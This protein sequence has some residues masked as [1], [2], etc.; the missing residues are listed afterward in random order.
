MKR[1]VP[2]SFEEQ[3]N[4]IKCSNKSYGNVFPVLR[5]PV[6]VQIYESIT[7][8]QCRACVQQILKR[9]GQSWSAWAFDIEW[10]VDFKVGGQRPVALMQFSR[11]N[12]VILF[13]IHRCGL[14]P[15]L[16]D[17]LKNP[18]IFL[19][20]VNISGDVKKIER[21]FATVLPGTIKGAVDLR[22]LEWKLL[23]H[24]SSNSLAGM[25]QARLRMTLEK[26][27]DVRTGNWEQN[28]TK[29]Q[30]DYAAL[31]VFSTYLLFHDIMKSVLAN[32]SVKDSNQEGFETP[33]AI[34]TFVFNTLSELSLKFISPS[35]V[36]AQPESICDAFDPSSSFLDRVVVC[37]CSSQKGR[38][39]LSVGAATKSSC[40]PQQSL[41]STSQ[42]LSSF[43]IRCA[44]R[45]ERASSSVETVESIESW[46]HSS[47]RG[48]ESAPDLGTQF[49]HI[50]TLGF[51]RAMVDIDGIRYRFDRIVQRRLMDQVN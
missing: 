49:N 43:C 39:P 15:E 11:E 27:Q 30:K 22:E 32:G 38:S 48:A 16:I 13:H 20:G 37:S 44:L 31:D 21:D 17:I 36:Y 29:E 1:T 40:G 14:Q 18:K 23:S 24:R 45:R 33:Q 26:P 7:P 5:L 19:L 47:S 42:T 6:D 12:I 25:V 10:R 2:V 35:P 3:S 28:L 50:G 34:S 8:T 51:L 9:T 41:P 4:Q 46:P